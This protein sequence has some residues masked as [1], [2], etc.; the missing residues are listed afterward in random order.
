MTDTMTRHRL[1]GG[2]PVL[3]VTR[4][5]HRLTAISLT[6]GSGARHDPPQAA[7]AFHLLEHLLMSAPLRGGRSVAERIERLGGVCN[8]QTGPESLVLHAQILTDHAPTVATMLCEALV[9]PVIDDAILDSERRV[10]LQEIAA[11]SADPAD[12]VQDAILGA[13]FPR[14]PLGSPVAGDVA[15]VRSVTLG[16]LIA[17]RQGALDHGPV[18]VSCVG[19]LPADELHAALDAGGLTGCRPGAPVVRA[20]GG[21][22]APLRCAPEPAWPP[23]FA[24]MIAGARAPAAHDPDRFASIL[25]G[26]LLGS[27]PCSLLYR[28]LR[29][30]QGLAY[31]FRAWSRSYSDCGAWRFMAGVDVGNGPRLLDTVRQTLAEVAQQ[32]PDSESH[33]AAVQQASTQ[34]LMEAESSIDRSLSSG[35]HYT[36]TGQMWD[37]AED[38]S[39]LRRVTAEEV[40]AAAASVLDSLVV[41]TRS[42][43]A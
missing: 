13:L 22:P 3:S 8:A 41:V 36:L 33:R 37:P 35:I 21:R 31:A 34:V 12:V 25:L 30:E 24:W 10:V 15:S 23:T 1:D 27:S 40:A 39:H 6:L 29:G 20:A 7:G 42:G 5:G 11:A 32:G 28:R 2:V 38:I 26:H 14:H 43:G 18:V 9:S 4:P 19:G 17:A 16:Q